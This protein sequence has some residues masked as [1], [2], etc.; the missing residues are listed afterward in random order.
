MPIFFALIALAAGYLVWSSRARAAHG[1]A[2]ELADMAGDVI[3]AARRFG[4]RRKANI[5]PVDALEDGDVAIAGAGVAF[6]ELA[7]LPSVETQDALARS[8]QVTLGQ[9]HDQAREALVLGRWLM[10]QCGG[11]VPA[12][13]RLTRRLAKL[14]GADS[15]TPLMQVLKD[16]A[17]ASGGSVT[18]AQKGALED[19]ARLYRLK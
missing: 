15:L 11:P 9:N 1:A 18:D 12:L 7:G 5:H 17:A 3:S 6:L 16:V 8:L 13:S 10:G 2:Q 14:K 4:F 19:I